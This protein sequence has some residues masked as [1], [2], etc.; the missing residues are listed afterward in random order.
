M[1]ESSEGKT[2]F[3]IR[4]A[5]M[6]TAAA[7]DMYH[8]PS[9]RGVLEAVAKGFTPQE[10]AFLRT[11]ATAPVWREFDVV[12]RASAVDFLGGRVYSKNAT[13]DFQGGRCSVGGHPA[14]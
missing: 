12:A 10:T 3:G 5:E 11:L 7:P 4:T 1:S 8:G 2:A 14:R 6:F 9:S 13:G